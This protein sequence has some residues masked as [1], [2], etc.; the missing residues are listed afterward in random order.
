MKS[1]LTPV[2]EVRV[3]ELPTLFDEQTLGS[4]ARV[5]L[6]D[7]AKIL[8]TRQ[9]LRHTVLIHKFRQMKD[10]D[11]NPCI[12]LV[13]GLA[14]SNQRSLDIEYNTYSLGQIEKQILDD[15]HRFV[16]ACQALPTRH[17][18]VAV[19]FAQRI[20]AACLNLPTE[21]IESEL[22]SRLQTLLSIRHKRFDG[23]LAGQAW[24]LHL[25]DLAP[26]DWL[27][28]VFEVRTRLTREKSGFTLNL[29]HPLTTPKGSRPVRRLRMPAR[30]RD[31]EI[32]LTLERAE[33][34][35]TPLD[36]NIRVGSRP[37]SD[38]LIVADFVALANNS[39]TR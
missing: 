19:Q 25:P 17:D 38:D 21:T 35:G 13:I 23:M 33:I 34:R 7:L 28:N 36:I 39:S 4:K 16:S 37:G 26:Y 5:L 30:P 14:L 18:L 11:G 6:Q 29:L 32:S 15:R 3:S 24:Q 9:L 27:P 2:L 8:D 31:V 10:S 20:A 1:L 22:S 12:M